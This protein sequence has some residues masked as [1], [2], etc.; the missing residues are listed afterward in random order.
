MFHVLTPAEELP[1]NT[2]VIVVYPVELEP[3]EFQYRT[4]AEF[5]VGEAGDRCMSIENDF[6]PYCSGPPCSEVDACRAPAGGESGGCQ[7]SDTPVWPVGLVMML[8]LVGLAG[9][10]RRVQ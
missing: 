5:S 9:R 4:L 6:M 8:L 3:G 1:A 2:M 10:R 7:A